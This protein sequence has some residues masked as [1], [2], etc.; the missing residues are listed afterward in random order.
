MTTEEIHAI[1]IEQFGDKAITGLNAE[2]IDGWIEVSAANIVDVCTFLRDDERLRFE[3]LN[4]LCGVDY[5]EPDEKKLKK[6]GHEPHLEVVYQLSSL[7]LKQRTKIKVKLDRWKGGKEGELPEIPSVTGVWGI[8]DWH[9][10]ECYD[11]FG[12]RFIDH[13]NMRR[14]LCPED[15]V[16][17][18]LRKDYEFPLEYHGVRGK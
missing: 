8:A 2:A 14:I 3:H 17:H 15:W 13:P 16:G 9:E 1:L 7:E 10:R 5:Y 4:D 11:M 6:F 18:P 12:I